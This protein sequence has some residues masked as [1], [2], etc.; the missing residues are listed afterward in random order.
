MSKAKPSIVTYHDDYQEAFRALNLTWLE[1]HFEVEETD[2][3][4][5]YDPYGTIIKPGGEIFFVM[6]PETRLHNN[7][8][9]ASPG[10]CNC[11]H[12]NET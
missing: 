4:Q 7:A 8:P 12:R 2:R 1:R 5:L 9:R 10:L 11:K 6:V 3:R